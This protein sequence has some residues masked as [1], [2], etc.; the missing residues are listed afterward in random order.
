[1]KERNIME[2]EAKEIKTNEINAKWKQ[3]L[4]E[5]EKE[6][7]LMIKQLLEAFAMRANKKGKK[8]RKGKGKGKK[9]K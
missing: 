4:L 8:G 2:E 1:M 5:N 3:F 9:K 6:K 7:E